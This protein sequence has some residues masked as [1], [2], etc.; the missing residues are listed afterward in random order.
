MHSLI[1]S[2]EQFNNRTL[3]LRFDSSATEVTVSR[4]IDKIILYKQMWK[5]R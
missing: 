2:K 4:G 5:A 1:S 3:L